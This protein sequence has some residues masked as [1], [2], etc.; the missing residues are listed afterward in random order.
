MREIIDTLN[1]MFKYVFQKWK[2]IFI[3]GIIGAVMGLAYS[4]YKKPTY[5]AT[6]TFV[7]EDGEGMGGALGQYAGLASM[8]GI[9]L[10]GASGG[11]IFKGDNIMELYK[12][13]SIIVKALMSKLDDKDLLIDR[14]IT[15]NNLKS[16]WADKPELKSINF[17]VP[18]N[19]FTVQH[20][21]ILTT[22]VKNINKNMLKV[23]K[24]DKKL[25][26]IKVEVEAK[27]EV[28]AKKF[29]ETLVKEVN[30]FYTET[31]TK[32]STE[33]LR[34]LQKQTDSVKSELKMAISGVANFNDA[35]PNANPSRQI[36]KVPSQNR[37]IDVK[38]NTAILEELVKNLEISKVSS[39]NNRPLIQ[40]IDSPIL[41]LQDDKVSLAKGGLIGLVLSVLLC[42]F[43]LSLRKLFNDLLET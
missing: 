28:F 21:S 24:P 6:L 35:I 10:G 32:K 27:D 38:A 40:V 22:A 13:R 12:S 15:F 30:E 20:D 25:N 33:N 26:I 5:T 42:I 31:K 37:Q 29:T 11:G 19:Q 39:R 2:L 7:L 14:Y 3:I 1:A 41:P 43:F 16:K 36:L 9:D 18:A 23:S 17:H 4:I 8:V 34:I